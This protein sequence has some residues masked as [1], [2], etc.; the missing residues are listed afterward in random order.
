V[1]FDNV[2]ALTTPQQVNTFQTPV[3]EEREES[4]Y[5]IFAS[6]ESPG[7]VSNEFDEE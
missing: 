5:E 2:E 3:S 6:P 7:V 1:Q 4:K